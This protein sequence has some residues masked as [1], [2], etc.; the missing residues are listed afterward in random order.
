[1]REPT[2]LESEIA[3]VTE[4]LRP[5]TPIKGE[6]T[7]WALEERMRHYRIPGVSL[8]V[9]RRGEIQWSQGFGVTASG[10]DG[11]VTKTTLFQACSMSKP[12]AAL[13][14]MM[15][16]EEG[17]LDIDA[18]V[19]TQIKSWSLP[20]SP[21]TVDKPVTLRHIMS[22]TGGLSVS[23]FEGYDRNADLPST[24]QILTGEAPAKSPPVFSI[25]P[26]GEQEIY[27]G[28]GTT[29]LQRILEEQENRPFAETLNDRM[30]K[31]LGMCN[32]GF[33]QPLPDTLAPKAACGHNEEGD[34]IEGGWRVFPELAAAGLWTTA[35]DY[36]RFLIALRYAEQHASPLPLE[37]STIEEILT[38]AV[39]S[40]FGLGP[41]TRGDGAARRFGHSGGNV[42]YRCDSLI[43]QESGDGA[44]VL[45]NGNGR[46]GGGW[47]F[48]QEILAAIATVYNWPDFVRAPVT[49]ISLTESQL[50]QYVG[51]YTFHNAGP[52]DMLHVSLDDG[53]LL[54][55]MGD[56]PAQP[57]FPVSPSVFCAQN[58]TREIR[59]SLKEK[60]L[61]ISD[62][63]AE[64]LRA[65][66]IVANSTGQ[67]SS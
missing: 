64:I 1:M 7:R 36:A 30:L 59:F 39:N 42:G 58:S 17:R 16:A 2:A 33:W 38:P 27:S 43:Y 13:C 15:L 34:L 14:I 26:P 61:I 9:I 52:Q 31:P 37:P 5:L 65:S 48:I 62:R 44:V 23:G 28:G 53:R 40:S 10:G 24:L 21:H 32:S 55:R 12:L 57:V 4:G 66:R 46:D 8:C 67:V 41:E 19:N 49:P 60:A 50:V 18:P 20:E 3:A 6:D 25:A 11:A 35:E 47:T 22:H 54:I 63:G 29:V 56:G 45:T 51:S